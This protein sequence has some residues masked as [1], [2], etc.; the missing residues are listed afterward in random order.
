MMNRVKSTTE[1][2]ELTNYYLKLAIVTKIK[3]LRSENFRR[4]FLPKTARL[5]GAVDTM[6]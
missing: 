5:R 3:I 2:S 1:L 6:R 4:Y